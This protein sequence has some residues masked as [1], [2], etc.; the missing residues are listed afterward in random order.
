[1]I[2]GLEPFHTAE[3]VEYRP[4]YV[5]GFIAEKYTVKMKAAWEKAKQKIASLLRG[6]VDG[7]IRAEHRADRTRNVQIQTDYADIT[8]KYLL[9]PVW[10][11]SFRYNDK[12]YHFMVN[13]QTGKV[14][15]NTPI[16]WIKVAIVA[17]AVI[18]VVAA[19]FLLTHSDAEAAVM[20]LSALS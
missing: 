18:A 1:M 9:L 19:V 5:A 2:A 3:A 13:G 20:G 16:S 14:S 11:S 17:L 4:E 7:K 12:V 6:E 15:G 10:I 8:Y